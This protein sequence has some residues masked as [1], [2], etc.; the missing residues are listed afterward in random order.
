[1]RDIE[2]NTIFWDVTLYGSCKNWRFGGRFLCSMLQLLV[3]ANVPSSLA[4]SF[5]PDDGDA[6]FLRNIGLTRAI[7]RHIPED[8]IL[9]S[10]CRENLKSYEIHH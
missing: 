6:I 4:V 7:Q 1:M 8:S 9:H 10:H 5:N 3:T 2:K